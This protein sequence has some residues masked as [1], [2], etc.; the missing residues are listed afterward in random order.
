[1][2]ALA[3]PSD[4]SAPDH[5]RAKKSHWFMGSDGPQ[6]KAI[7]R[8]LFAM[9]T[10]G[11]A[12][13]FLLAA[14]FFKLM[15]PWQVAVQSAYQ[16]T[17]VLLFYAV[18]RSGRT[19]SL[20][21]PAIAFP[22]V[23]F[24]ISAIVLTYGVTEHARGSALQMMCL[25][26][27][28]DMQRLTERQIGLA[29]FGAVGLLGL[30]LFV[31]WWMAPETIQLRR[32]IINITMAAVQLPV[33]TMIARVVRRMRARQIEQGI[34]LKKTLTQLHELSIH[35]ALTGIFNRRH[36]LDVL[37]EEIKRHARS[38]RPF[39]VAIL[40]IDHFKQVND[41]HGHAV[42]DIVLREFAKIA[43][44][45]VGLSNTLCRWGGEEFLLLIPESDIPQA[46][47]VLADVRERI[48]QHDWTQYAPNLAVRF[49]AGVTQYVLQDTVASALER[50]DQGLYQAK[51]RGRDQAIAMEGSP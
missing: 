8:M 42:G 38:H 13:L 32:E 29:A 20:P 24:A 11:V 37:Q 15:E 43:Q 3:T 5:A 50:A 33:I 26:L 1:M 22:Q 45:T 19:L 41:Q 28:F 35:D 48:A 7:K 49:S 12:N 17:G 10:Y 14:Y 39:C 47:A 18:V 34:A 2:Q 36:M 6:R 27:V 25:I 9:G 40:D 31:T 51:E 4:L 30:T 23:L 46:M 44:S 21:D 16:V